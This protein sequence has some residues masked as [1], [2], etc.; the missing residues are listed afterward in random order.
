MDEQN[1]NLIL[2]MVLSLAVMMI[3]FVIFPPEQ[4]TPIEDQDIAAQ[5]DGALTPPTTQQSADAPTTITQSDDAPVT[6]SAADLPR[7]AIQT[8]RLAGSISLLGGRIDTLDLSDYRTELEDGAPTVSLLAPTNTPNPYF[9]YHGWWPELG[10]GLAFADLPNA[11]TPWSLISGET[12]TPDSPLV[13][14]WSNG[15]GLSFERQIEIDDNYMFTITQSVTNA[16]ATDMRLSPFG[17]VERRGEPQ[18]LSGFFIIHEGAI[19]MADGELDEID[20]DKL[21]DSDFDREFQGAV[22]RVEVETEGWLGFTDHYWMTLLIP[23]EGR[24]FSAIF[25]YQDSGQSYQSIARMEAVT[26]S[27][28]A[29]VTVTSQLFA[30]AKEWETIR[31]YEA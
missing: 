31:N 9:A 14:E 2:A 15:K 4:P 13:M 25:N 30:G 23:E 3:W 5:N 17:Q 27:P 7:V 10:S 11:N 18:D 1:R 26:V 24:P 6:V 28:G 8:D 22:D 16:G 29:T 21:P 20:Y 19:R 12:L